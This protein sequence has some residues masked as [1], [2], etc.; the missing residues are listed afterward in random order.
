MK[1]SVSS[2]QSAP[3]PWRTLRYINIV[4]S[5]RKE[6]RKSCLGT[7]TFYRCADVQCPF[8]ERCQ[9]LVSPWFF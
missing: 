3:A 4:E 6:E 9:R 7:S 8:R 1:T 5:A 2:P